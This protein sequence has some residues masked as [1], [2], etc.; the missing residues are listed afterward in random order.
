M[1]HPEHSDV[2]AEY[3]KM[4]LTKVEWDP[5]PNGLMYFAGPM[6]IIGPVNYA[7]DYKDTGNLVFHEDTI[8]RGSYTLDHDEFMKYKKG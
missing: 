3:F 2:I 4:V 6:V 8:H 5:E 7:D 1:K